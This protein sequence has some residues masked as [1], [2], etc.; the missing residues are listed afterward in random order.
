MIEN[1]IL[2][3]DH[4]L[5]HCPESFSMRGPGPISRE[6]FGFLRYHNVIIDDTVYLIFERP[7]LG[8][9]LKS[10]RNKRVA[11][12]TAADRQY[13]EY[14][15]KFIIQPYLHPK[16]PIEFVWSRSS[17]DES[18][19]RFGVLKNLDLVFEK[20]GPKFNRENTLIIDDNYDLLNQ[21]NK[22]FVIKKFFV[23][24]QD[25]TELLKLMQ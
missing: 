25:D 5:I 22:V 23:Q 24:N 6:R 10:L 3:L 14:I 7:F 17:C 15:V 2:D 21:K 1:I 13:A 9:F 20:H 11:I 16:Q 8:P 19:S 18:S 4:T 12:W